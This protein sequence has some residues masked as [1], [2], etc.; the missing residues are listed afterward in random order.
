MSL[1]N[2]PTNDART[3]TPMQAEQSKEHFTAPGCTMVQ[4]GVVALIM[5]SGFPIWKLALAMFIP[6]ATQ[7]SYGL[8]FIAI[9]FFLVILGIGGVITAIKT[10]RKG[11]SS[12]RTLAGLGLGVFVL[13]T[14]IAVVWQVG[15]LN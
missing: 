7:Q 9:G 12:A 1:V 11:N 5:C 6:R 4:D 13:G 15:L 2:P 10:L 14:V 3:A 8:H